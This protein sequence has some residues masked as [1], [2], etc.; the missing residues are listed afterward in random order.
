M[1]KKED[2]PLG[3]RVLMWGTSIRW[4]GWG[5]GEAFIPIFL[6]LFSASFL[7]TGALAAVYNIVF[8]L[9]IP[10][11]G[12]LADNFK[13]KSMVLAGLVIYVFIGAGYFLAGLTGLVVFIII[14]RGLN[15]ISYSFDL[16]ARESY[17]MRHSPKNKAS[18]IFGRFDSVANFWWLLAVVVGL[19]VVKLTN[20]PIHWLLFFIIPTSIISFFVVLK[21]REKPK[22]KKK[23]FS[24]GG[25]YMKFFKDL[26]KF[27]KAIKLLV[28]ISFILGITSS[29]IY[30]FVPISSY[31][32][33]NGILSAAVLAFVY[34]LP[35]LFG[36]KLGKIADTHRERIYSLGLLF[37]ILIT[38][39][40]VLFKNYVLMLVLMFFA[41]TVFELIYLARK[42]TITRLADRTH[43]GE[44]DGSMN[45][46]AALGAVIGPVA[47]G[48][49]IDR[50][51][52][53]FAYL[54]LTGLL[55]LSLGVV[56]SKRKIFE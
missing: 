42:G 17:I 40:L 55:V 9:S 8:F 37:L 12:Y 56:F 26:K 10:L 52:M 53:S 19:I 31:L 39:G 47:F 36:S 13:S 45:G 44:V 6:L 15:G 28:F 18:G 22:Q 34:T 46:V 51:Q 32:D 21:L 14:A 48:F 23:T 33:G 25:A 41:S 43:L 27:N 11:A 5:F 16:I 49:L 3:V 54:F 1:L 30:F 4:I 38:F 7:E 20:I 29:I 2:M 50:I 24:L 35:Y